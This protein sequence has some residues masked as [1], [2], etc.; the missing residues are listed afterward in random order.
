MKNRKRHWGHIVS[1]EIWLDKSYQGDSESGVHIFR[2]GV[3][4]DL[5]TLWIDNHNSVY[6]DD[7]ALKEA[8]KEAGLSYSSVLVTQ[9]RQVKRTRKHTK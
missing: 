9:T 8:I 6:S 3:T 4:N 5:R 7:K 1:K 2:F